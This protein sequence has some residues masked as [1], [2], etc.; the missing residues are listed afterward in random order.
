MNLTSF[1]DSIITGINQYTPV[2]VFHPFRMTKKEKALFDLTISKS[3]VHLEFGMGGSTFRA[4]QK[5][6]AQIYSIDSSEPWIAMMKKYL[7]IKNHE[8]KRLFVT[9]VD[10]GPTH[11]WGRPVGSNHRD[12]Y[13]AYSSE[14][15][16]SIDCASIDT[17][18]VDGRFRVACALKSLMECGSNEGFK[19]LFH[20]FHREHYHIV[21][22]FF[23]SEVQVD[24]LILLS[25]KPE[26]D[27]VKLQAIYDE[28]KYND[29]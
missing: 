4:L 26:Y 16:E 28:Y 13:P 27:T 15:F 12:L 17:V 6:D 29:D 8:G 25:P 1:F 21:L 23:N 19:V 3:K 14:I 5:S 9:Q 7:F 24:D 22:E 2:P 10:I 11:E 18:L 20:D